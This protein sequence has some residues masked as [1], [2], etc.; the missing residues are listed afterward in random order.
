MYM[1]IS[2]Y[3][4]ILYINKITSENIQD[5]IEASTYIWEEEN[6][7]VNICRMHEYKSV[8][9]QTNWTK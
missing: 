3:T 2:L 9:I 8:K 1:Q 5:L 4:N 6:I 7:Y